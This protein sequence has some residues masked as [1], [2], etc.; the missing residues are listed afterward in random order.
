[1]TTLS[2]GSAMVPNLDFSEISSVASHMKHN[3]VRSVI[4]SVTQKSQ[5]IIAANCLPRFLV[6]SID[7]K[8][9]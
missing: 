2:F 9:S 1:V 4:C 7:T 8:M 6:S 3:D 5:I